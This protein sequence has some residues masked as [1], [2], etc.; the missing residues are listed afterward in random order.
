MVMV[1]IEQ[2]F[3]TQDLGCIHY[4]THTHSVKHVYDSMGQI[5]ELLSNVSRFPLK[6]YSIKM[7]S[8]TRQRSCP[9]RSSAPMAVATL[10]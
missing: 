2:Q 4:N 3:T 5:V 6:R 10:I 1:L 9:P 7:S 8:T